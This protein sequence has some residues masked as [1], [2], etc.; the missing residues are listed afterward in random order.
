MQ[1]LFFMAL[2]SCFGVEGGCTAVMQRYVHV[3]V[4]DTGVLYTGQERGWPLLTLS[5]KEKREERACWRCDTTCCSYP[6]VRERA[7]NNTQ[8]SSPSD[9]CPVL[10]QSRFFC[11]YRACYF[12]SRSS[13]CIYLAVFSVVVLFSSLIHYIQQIHLLDIPPRLHA[14]DVIKHCWVFPYL[15]LKYLALAKEVEVRIMAP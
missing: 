10:Y 3:E 7:R 11:L 4:W 8:A 15:M 12:F 14:R 6:R 1:L 13:A 5:P 2:I 9:T